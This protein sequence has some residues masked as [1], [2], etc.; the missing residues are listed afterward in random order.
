LIGT[1]LL[2]NQMIVDHPA[3]NLQEAACWLEERKF[4][5]S[6]QTFPSELMERLD[7]LRGS[8]VNALF[9]LRTTGGSDWLSCKEVMLDL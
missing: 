3:T 4:R 6:C 9:H 2:N 8:D 1:L 7:W 5:A